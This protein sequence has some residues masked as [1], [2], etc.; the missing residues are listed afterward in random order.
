MVAVVHKSA[1]IQQHRAES[2]ARE[3]VHYLEIL[4][5]VVLRQNCF[6]QR[7]QCGNVPLSIG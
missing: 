6:Q 4:K 1:G 3:V 5:L 7:P 2:D